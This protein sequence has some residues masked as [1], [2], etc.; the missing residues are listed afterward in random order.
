MTKI[1]IT[2]SAGFI[3]SSTARQLLARGDQVIGLDNFNDYY[4]VNQKNNNTAKLE[5]DFPQSFEQIRGDIL[6]YQLLSELFKTQKIHKICHLAARAGVRP[7]IAD[8]FLYE[9][10]NVRGTLNL[11]EIARQHQVQNFVFASSSSVYG[12]SR[13]IPFTET[14]KLDAPISPYAATKKATENLAYTY[15]YLYQLPTIALRFFTV[16]GPAGRP[17]M[18]PFLFTKWISEGKPLTLF[19]DGTAAR[20]FTY[21]DDIVRGVVAALDLQ[22]Q[23]EIINLGRGSPVV[24]KDFIAI[25]EKL[26]GKK[27]IIDQK[28]PFPGDVPITYANI[29]KAEKLLGVR[30]EVSVEEGMERF[31][32]WLVQEIKK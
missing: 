20:D 10:V 26:L 9:K 21:I 3:G 8:P 28:P 7:S 16:F 14:Q 13:E 19:G 32:K 6:D 2:G 31:V 24:I 23:F 5:A 18:A 12:E 17:D 25:I 11:L 30:P 1:L 15:Y 29:T 4:S 22:A 27:A